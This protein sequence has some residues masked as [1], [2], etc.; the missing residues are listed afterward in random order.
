MDLKLESINIFDFDGTL[1]TETWPKFWVWV[2]KYGYDGKKR[3]E[4]LEFALAQYRKVN[5]GNELE[6]FFGFFNSLLQKNNDTI[7]LEELMNGEKYIKYNPGVIDFLKNNNAKNYIVSGGI[8]EFLNNLSISSYF[9]EIYGTPLIWEKN[10]ICGIGSVMTDDKKIVAIK[11]IL[12][13]NNRKNND[14][15][16]VYYI[17]DGYSD[18]AAM[19]FV[20]RNGGKAIFVHQPNKDDELYQH[21]LEIYELLNKNN[22]VDFCCIADYTKNSKLYNILKRL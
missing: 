16:N 20:H 15:R 1:T 2:E 21:N 9:E 14:C 13:D 17:G 18:Y 5:I 11:E 10:K 6:T 19:E 12:K 8:K 3:N 4:E 22:I 7:T